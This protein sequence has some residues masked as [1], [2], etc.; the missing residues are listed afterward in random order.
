MYDGHAASK[1]FNQEVSRNVA[2]GYSKAPISHSY[3]GCYKERREWL[4]YGTLSAAFEPAWP[5]NAA[6]PACLGLSPYRWRHSA[7]VKLRWPNG[8]SNEIANRADLGN[9]IYGLTDGGHVESREIELSSQ[10]GTGKG[11]KR[12]EGF[13]GL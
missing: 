13:A 5:V 10:A 2:Q 12:K 3:Y 11:R 4:K 1:F 9:R 6:Y 8:G 7:S